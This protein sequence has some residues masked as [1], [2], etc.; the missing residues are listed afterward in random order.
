[1]EIRRGGEDLKKKDRNIKWCPGCNIKRRGRGEVEVSR[2]AE[3]EGAY[4]KSLGRTQ[5]VKI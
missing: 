1:L 3:R 4:S 2:R 5:G